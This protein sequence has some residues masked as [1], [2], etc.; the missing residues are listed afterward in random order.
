MSQP[1]N[2]GSPVLCLSAETDDG[3]VVVA[4]LS[5]LSTHL[6]GGS[7]LYDLLFQIVS[8]GRDGSSEMLVGPVEFPWTE[9]Y[10]EQ[11]FP[12]LKSSRTLVHDNLVSIV[13]PS[14]LYGVIMAQGDIQTGE[15]TVDPRLAHGF[16]SRAGYEIGDASYAF[17]ARPD[18]VLAALNVEHE[19]T[20]G[21]CV[22]DRY[23]VLLGLDGEQVGEPRSISSSNACLVTDPAPEQPGRSALEWSGSYFGYCDLDQTQEELVYRFWLLDGDGETVS[24]PCDLFWPSAVGMPQTHYKGGYEC[25]VVALGQSSFAVGIT[26][27][28]TLA[29]LADE[30]ISPGVYL[31]MVEYEIPR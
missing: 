6:G 20:S 29:G 23:S 12:S 30:D 7:Y 27:S 8:I 2:S 18:E 15:V 16:P 3:K 22:T 14:Q 5:T 11:G 13:A 25:D 28:D 31:T 24:G 10:L 4:D 9:T 1:E 26:V 19:E 17:E 21:G